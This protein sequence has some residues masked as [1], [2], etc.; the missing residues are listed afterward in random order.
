MRTSFQHLGTLYRPVCAVLTNSS[1]SPRYGQKVIFG[2]KW[3]FFFDSAIWG[4][5]MSI[6][7]FS[8]NGWGIEEIGR[9]PF[10][11]PLEPSIHRYKRRGPTPRLARDMT[12]FWP[13]WAH[14]GL[15]GGSKNEY[16]QFCS[17]MVRNQRNHPAI[18]F[19]ALRPLHHPIQVAEV[20]STASPRYDR[21]SG[22][23]GP[24]RAQNTTK[25]VK[26]W[27]KVRKN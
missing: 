7:T 16:F 10:L 20:N 22:Q 2:P 13:F 8:R 12:D 6:F 27:K 18:F 23:N 19:E 11:K 26:K 14:L 24:A 3:P 9:R 1:R 25:W 5:K 17:K 15:F 4:Q 21:F